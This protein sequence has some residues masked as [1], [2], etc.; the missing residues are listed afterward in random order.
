MQEHSSLASPKSFVCE[1]PELV[2]LDTVCDQSS[3]EVLI[4]L[5]DLGDGRKQ[6]L[7][8]HENDNP[9]ILAIEFCKTHLLGPRVKIAICDEIEKHLQSVSS[10][11]PE[12]EFLPI[13]KSKPAVKRKG[14]IGHDLYVKGVRMKEKLEK[15]NSRIRDMKL[16]EEMR[17]TTFS[18]EINPTKRRT[19]RTETILL[20][21]GRA[22]QEKIRLKRSEKELSIMAECTFSPEIDRNSVKIHENNRKSLQRFKHL[23]AN[24]EDT[25]IKIK[26]NSLKL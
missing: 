26:Q 1:T 18:P 21:K 10:A 17:G 25:R 24:A 8:V 3:T 19:E 13:E 23:Y 2:S 9:E 5:I 16:A 7:T 4:L 6:N 22:S 11:S 20:E 15:R 12:Q 14:N